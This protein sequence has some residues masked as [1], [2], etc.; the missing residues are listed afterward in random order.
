MPR[1]DG[2]CPRAR[3]AD[4]ACC[5]AGT[6]WY[7][8]LDA[9]T[10]AWDSDALLLHLLH[11]LVRVQTPVARILEVPGR[12]IYGPT[13]SWAYCQQPTHQAAHQVL[14]GTR[15]D[16]GVVCPCSTRSVTAAV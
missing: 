14:A 6:V 7:L 8:G 4:A 15:G 12:V 16:D 2:L 3:K 11:E 13:E 1:Q 5:T 9:V 10:D